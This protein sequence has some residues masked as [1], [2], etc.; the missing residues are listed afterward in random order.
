VEPRGRRS[1]CAVLDRLINAIRSGESRV[2][3][4]RG[5]PGVGK[6]ALLDY[7]ARQ[8]SG[9]RVVRSVG[10]Q[11][12]MELAFAGL[13]QLCLSMLD[14]AER[15]PGPQREALRIAFGL[16]AGP[17]PD[18]FLV[19]LAVL[20]LLSEVA[21]ERPLI[22]LV[23]DQQWLDQAS[24]Q[25]L[26]FAARRL[27][28]DPV[29]LIFAARV[30]GDDVARL[31][32]LVLEGLRYAEARGLLDSVLTGP[33]DG[34]VRDQIV[35]ET[36]GN[37]LALLE[38]PRGLT[39]AQL[40]GGF[41][42]P[43]ARSLPGRIEDSF[44][45]QLDALPEPTRRL[46]QLAAAD[47]SGDPLLVWQAAGRLGIPVQAGAPAVEAALVE[48]GARVRFRHPLARSAAYQSA[49]A[50]QRQGIHSAL[51][52]VT[53]PAADPDRRAWHRAQATS[54]PDENVA[55]ELEGSAAR[56]QARGGLAAAAAFLERAAWLTPSPT[57]R[58]ERLLAAAKAKRDAGALDAALDHL[59]DA[60]T[61]PLGELLAAEV[62]HLRG[63]IA[64]DQMRGG[65][66]ARMLLNAARR[67]EALSIGLARATYLE[68]LGAAL[69]AGDL[70][71][72]GGVQEAAGAA[73][74]AAPWP[75][76]PRAVDVLLDAVALRFTEGYAA[77]APALARALEML[78]ALG[79]SPDGNGRQ[80]WLAAARSS[81]VI[82]LELWDFESWRALHAGQVTVARETGALVHLQFT[83]GYLARVH[84]LA[85]ELA[86]AAR[87][88]EEDRLI[89]EAT[90]NPPIEHAAMMLAAW[91]GRE[92]EASDLIDTI[93]QEAAAR[94][95][96]GLV[97]YATCARAVLYNGLGRYGAACDVARRAFEPDVERQRDPAMFGLYGSLVVPELAE[98]AA[99]TGDMALV[100]AALDWLS[101]RTQVTPT[102]WVLGI[103][104][105]VRAL[106]G[107]GDAADSCYRMS[108]AYLS[109]TR[110]RAQLARSHLLYGEWLRS[111]KRHGDAQEQLRAAWQMLDQMGMEAFAERA[112]RELLAIGETIPNRTAPPAH[113][114]LGQVSDL[115]TAQEA[116][117][118]RLARGGL[119]NPE[120]AA[121]LFISPRTVE[122]HLRKVF[123]KLGISSRRQLNRVLPTDT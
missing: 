21:G 106:L 114:L 110:V 39:P 48:F 78:L 50:E 109:R 96:G 28:A 72:P 47:P 7:L 4:V 19:G 5:E 112:R 53:D 62:E 23:D 9:C 29:G 80:F 27:A 84:I 34:R 56:A 69:W 117:I 77:A 1:E 25:A 100:R 65:S 120:I 16:S 14:H 119:S 24:A 55:S 93:S 81:G 66:A 91:Q 38:L 122:W 88:V 54:G 105:L 30:P 90:G 43:A 33:V 63:Q 104:S 101:E 11:S 51:A 85:G 2:L 18:R 31:P 64:L 12:E 41:G 22:C 107:E 118:A 17:A 111:Q 95:V 37:P 87:L 113:T 45:R 103:E 83:L 73:R 57:R 121:R 99:R 67:F 46:L 8:A 42:L 10:M 15:L 75:G 58:A 89:A 108:I 26:G 74:A 6:T 61:G 82:A 94:G 115:L 13:H 3:V 97:D 86:A 59:G 102:D 52:E 44:R 36:R 98:A 76:P 40:A 49:S 92:R 116:Q 68:A 20:G 70:D 60:Q 71:W 35:A 32:E 123:T 79:A